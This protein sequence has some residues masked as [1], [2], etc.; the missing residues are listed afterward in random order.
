[1]RVQEFLGQAASLRAK[2]EKILVPEAGLGVG[3]PGLLRE[4]EEMV[5]PVF[6]K[7]ILPGVME[8]NIHILPIVEPG[9]L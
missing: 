2:D 6:Q 4:E 1:V 9:T 8:A 7:E 5:G 3:I